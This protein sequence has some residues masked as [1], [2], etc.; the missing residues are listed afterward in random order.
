[1]CHQ[2][3]RKNSHN[4]ERKKLSEC[5]RAIVC[6]TSSVFGFV[7]KKKKI[8][9][10]YSPIIYRIYFSMFVSV[11]GGNK[12]GS[13]GIRFCSDKTV[14]PPAGDRHTTNNHQHKQKPITLRF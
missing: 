12:G 13:G 1:M 7:V 6:P 2:D 14:R 10:K 3:C 4:G 11:S 8:K 9:K 5:D